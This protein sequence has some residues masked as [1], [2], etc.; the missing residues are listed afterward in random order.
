M[1]KA[2]YII[3]I[4]DLIHAQKVVTLADIQTAFPDRTRI[5]IVR[6]LQVIGTISSYNKSGSF[7]TLATIPEYNTEGIWQFRS[8]L[9]SAYG[10]LMNTVKHHVSA[11]PN[12]MT[13]E[14]LEIIL[15]MPVYNEL[16]KLTQ[17]SQ[18]VR[19]KPVVACGAR[20]TGVNM[21]FSA[22][23]AVRALQM[24][25]RVRQS[26]PFASM[27]PAGMYAAY[28]VLRTFIEHTSLDAADIHKLLRLRS[29]GISL[30]QVEEV[31][32]MYDLGKKNDP[33][34]S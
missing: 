27:E 6:Y 26:A 31:F 33:S 4:T 18:I 23:S 21:Y 11:S 24:E 16:R 15:R 13:Q 34:A 12:G 9:F 8:A 1:G 32:S 5:S 2:D 29:T 19:E 14:E 7:L 25:T 28:E 22:D 10:S 30:N 3:K 20:R 17:E